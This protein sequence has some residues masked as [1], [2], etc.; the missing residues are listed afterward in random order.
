MKEADF[1]ILLIS[2]FNGE[3]IGTR[4]LFSAMKVRGYD[5]KLLFFKVEFEKEYEKRQHDSFTDNKKMVTEQEI[6][7]LVEYVAELKPDIISFSLVSPYFQLYKQLYSQIR[8]VGCFKIVVGGW[9][10]SLNPE[11]SIPYCDIL[12]VGEGDDAF[13][14]LV[15]CI[16]N[17][18]PVGNIPNLWVNWND[19][20][21]RNDVRPLNTNLDLLPNI[22]FD[23][24]STFYIEN[25]HLVNRDPY[26]EN[27]RYGIMAG[28]GCPYHCTYCSNSYMAKKVY[29]R[30]WS[31]IRHRSVDHVMNE[32]IEVKGNFPNIK[33]INF[34]DEVFIPDKAW[35]EE[36][37]SRF[38]NEICLP[39]YCEFYPGTCKEELLKILKKGGLV[40]V[41]L[42]VQSGSE[43]V[44][45]EVFKRDYSNSQIIQQANMFKKYNISVRHDFIFDN[46][47]ESFQ[48]SLDSIDLMLELPEPFSLN[49]FSL[50]YFPNTDITKMALDANI[51]NIQMID[52]HVIWDR[53]HNYC[54]SQKND[55]SPGNFINNL[56]M[57][58]SLLAN[59][60]ELQINKLDILRLIDDYKL[61]QNSQPVKE[62]LSPFL[63]NP[64]T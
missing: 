5:T 36:F 7:L 15:D 17:N 37:F 43:R 42:G 50:K 29:P 31:K 18:Q 27:S 21:N 20:I 48:E 34:Y 19:R 24:V 12:C 49:L 14:E 47:F 30:Q 52:D 32:L 46:P 59:M 63:E 8:D 40:G 6:S 11:D 57:Y 62:L 38:K 53:R 9:Q 28:R 3:A 41:W 33:K 56:V 22:V 39:F 54:I 58:V 61:T 2:L 45:K 64:K 13:P 26:S 23:P 4:Q 25:N 35:A 10:A 51:I 55:D 16:Y 44:R 60:G 1:K